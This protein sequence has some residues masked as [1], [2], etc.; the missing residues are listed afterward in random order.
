[1]IKEIYQ[2]LNKEKRSTEINSYKSAK[3]HALEVYPALKKH[4]RERMLRILGKWLLWSLPV[5]AL[6]V[7]MCIRYTHV[8]IPLIGAVLLF[9]VFW[10]IVAP[11]HNFKRFHGTITDLTAIV[12]SVKGNRGWVI[13][14]ASLMDSIVLVVTVQLPDGTTRNVEVNAR[15]EEVLEVGDELIYLPG[16]AHPIHMTP[17]LRNICPSCGD[18]VSWE[19]DRCPGCGKENI[20]YENA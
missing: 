1:M 6:A 11:L 5:L 8:A 13:T 7:Y 17:G 9:V 4:R 12:K 16:L 18:L 20:Y 15:Y 10:R 3:R 19:F 14:S 2:A